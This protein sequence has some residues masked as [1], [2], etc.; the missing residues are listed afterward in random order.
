M[1]RRA[2]QRRDKRAPWQDHDD[3]G[4]APVH[5]RFRATPHQGRNHR[6]AKDG[7]AQHPGADGGL[8]TQQKG[9]QVHGNPL[10]GSVD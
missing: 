5:H 2:R 9:D 10:G 6:R 3:K 8:H 1:S 7:S 4:P